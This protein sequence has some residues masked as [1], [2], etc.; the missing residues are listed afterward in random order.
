M[1]SGTSG[2]EVREIEKSTVQHE[3]RVEITG[4]NTLNIPPGVST[5]TG[6]CTALSEIN[7]LSFQPHMHQLGTHLTY[8]VTP[9]AGSPYM[10]YDQDYTFDGQEHVMFDPVR[11]LH[12]G[13]QLKIDCT[14][15]NTT[16]N[17]VTFGESSNDEMCLAGI[18]LY[19]YNAN[20]CQ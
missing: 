4:T 3:A 20:F 17:T 8:T 7:V 18:T 14:Y 15:N 9:A 11:T 1:L 12:S 16:G 13:D 5:Q 2:V 19:P 10:L 6:T